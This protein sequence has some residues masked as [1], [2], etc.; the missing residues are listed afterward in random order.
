M[1]KIIINSRRI[2][3]VTRSEKFVSEAFDCIAQSLSAFKVSSRCHVNANFLIVTT[4]GQKWRE[5]H[6]P[7]LCS[8]LGVDV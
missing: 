8:A 3:L 5:D 6:S 4:G 2:I 7:R 1:Q